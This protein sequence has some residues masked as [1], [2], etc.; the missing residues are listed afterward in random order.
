[1]PGAYLSTAPG[2]AGIIGNPTDMY[3]GSVISCSTRERAA[4]LIEPADV[5]SFEVAD[6]RRVIQ[7]SDELKP[8][9]GY[10]DVAMAV[11]DYLNLKNARFSLRWAC[12]VPFRAGLSSSSALIVSILNA[13]LAYMGRSVHVY[14]RAE[15]ARH[16]ELHY[17]VLC[18]YQDA[19]MCTIGGLNFMDFREKQFYRA[20]ADEPYAT[21]EPLAPFIEDCPFILAHTGVKRN[22]AGVHQPIRERWLEGDREVV[23]S[24]LR[25]AHVARMG[26]RA[27][28]EADWRTLG[29]LMAENHEIQR[30]L[31]GSGPENE[32]LIQAALRGGALG[33]KLA[34]A[35]AGGTIV[36]LAPE[37][38][39][40]VRALWNAGAS[41]ILSPMPAPGVTVT[42]LETEAERHAAE[43]ELLKRSRQEDLKDESGTRPGARRQTSFGTHP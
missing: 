41:R 19:Y 13:V 18:G 7:P 2:R 1:M 37:P 24:Y 4:V 17:L 6:C 26:K 3:G 29:E 23:R 10:F 8:E 21:V 30:D 40:V 22:S 39:P 33:A 16:I 11:V 38:E 31:G 25:I 35:G 14:Y 36:A 9:G 27:L 42:A 5:L 28:L 32:C 12:D 15:M 20:L 34:G 43:A